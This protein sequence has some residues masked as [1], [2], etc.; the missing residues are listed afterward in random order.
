MKECLCS[1]ITVCYN[2]EKTIKKTIESVL[3]QTYQNVE[4][5]IVD[6][7]STDSTMKIVKEFEP[8]FNGR[9]R[10]ISEKDYGIY[11]AMNKGIQ[12]AS[13]EL[14]GIINSDDFYEL[15]A[16]EHMVN[17]MTEA[18]Y[19]ILYGAVRTLKNGV[20]RSI[21]IGSHLFLREAMI[22]HPACFVTKKLYDDFGCY[23]AQY[24]SAADYDFML[25]MSENKNVIF[26]PVYQVIANFSLGGMC[27][28]SR[29]YYD[30]L[31]VQKKHQ[32]ITGKEYRKTVFKCRIYDFLH[33]KK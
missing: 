7:N 32:I 28:S 19:Q 1:V 15:D 11:D 25:R 17:A 16:V 29:A 10:W 20:E 4:Y 33:G 6:G 3:Y 13:G 30:L 23:D 9:M 8:L 27:A 21:A 12:M 26:K 24:I 5:I 31:K 18:P 14:I 22:G 2:S